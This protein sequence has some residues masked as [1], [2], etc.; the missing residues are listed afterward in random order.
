M[1][2]EN[3]TT[4][5]GMA[6]CGQTVS[7]SLRSKETCG[8]VRNML[9]FIGAAVLTL[10][11]A[12][13]TDSSYDLNEVDATIGIGGDSLSLPV[14][15][16]EDIMPEEVLELDN[17]DFLFTD[18]DG[19]YMFE[20][21]GG[22]I[23][24]VEVEVAKTVVRCRDLTNT[25]VSIGQVATRSAGD[26]SVSGV[27][28]TMKYS[29]EC[30]A[31]VKSLSSTDVDAPLSF[32]LTF[33]EGLKHALPTIKS[34]TLTLPPYF[35]LDDG[36]NTVHL[37]NVSTSRALSIDSHVKALRFGL[38]TPADNS[39]TMHGGTISMT[40]KITI[41]AVI[42][43]SSL[44]TAT[45]SM[46][47]DCQTSLGDVTLEGATGQF[48]PAIK[49]NDIGDVRISSVPD[50]LTDEEANVGLYNPQIIISL[51]NDADVGGTVDGTI[52]TYDKQGRKLMSVD[53]DGMSIAPG[54]TSSILLCRTTDGVRTDGYTQVKAVPGLGDMVRRIPSRISFSASTHADDSRQSAIRFGHKYHIKPHFT[55]RAPLAL[56][57]DACIVYNDT[58]DGWHDDIDDIEL[59][60]GAELLLRANV[61]NKMPLSLTVSATAITPDGHA[62]PHDDILIDVSNTVRGSADGVNATVTPITIRLK[63]CRKGAI[64]SIDGIALHVVATSPSDDASAAAVTLN[65]K[66]H[67]LRLTDIRVTMKGKV[68]GDF[69]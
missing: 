4:A 14:S 6:L 65:S 41:D 16:T 39:L 28:T 68:I 29:G 10:S 46:Y 21:N 13:C 5:R 15:S 38:S 53:I 43:A 57:S 55:F 2:K 9:A 47:I 51:D 69:N 24:P 63:E 12:S 66:R 34:L 45:G 61:A 1:K 35:V 11:A 3:T 17:S 32:R 44:A 30:P 18:E 23:S 36:T 26:V 37:S 27:V 19:D 49:L 33:S 58:L 31:D 20:A 50:F 8:R 54:Q 64:K 59:S 60:E 7:A 62:V 67:T 48:C 22:D 25:R 42:D 40:G 56:A 52:T